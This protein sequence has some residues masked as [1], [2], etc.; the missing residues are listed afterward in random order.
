MGWADNSA[1]SQNAFLYSNGVMQNLNNLLG[2]ASSED[3]LT[4]ATG[5]NKNGQIAVNG[6]ITATGQSMGFLLTPVTSTS[7]A[8]VPAPETLGLFAAAMA[9]LLLMR[10]KKTRLLS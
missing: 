7:S 2:S 3:T 9:G 4:S 10:R 1:G 8:G 5:I 6:T